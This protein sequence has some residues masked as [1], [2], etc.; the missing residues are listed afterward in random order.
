MAGSDGGWASLQEFCPGGTLA[1]LLAQ[2]SKQRIITIIVH[3]TMALPCV[4][5]PSLVRRGVAPPVARRRWWLVQLCAVATV[6][7]QLLDV[8]LGGACNHGC[9][10][11]WLVLRWAAWSKSSCPDIACFVKMLSNICQIIVPSR[12]QAADR[13]EAGTG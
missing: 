11:S 13:Q 9:W 5:V 1:M 3:E 8:G 4:T 2:G 6:A 7:Y 10:T 12:R